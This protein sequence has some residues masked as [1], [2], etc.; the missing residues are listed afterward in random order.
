MGSSLCKELSLFFVENVEFQYPDGEGKCPFGRNP[1]LYFLSINK[2]R[3]DFK[4]VKTLDHYKQT[5]VL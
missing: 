5:H 3:M 1:F 4:H 2:C